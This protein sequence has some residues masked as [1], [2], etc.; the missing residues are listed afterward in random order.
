MT[1]YGGKAGD[2][3]SLMVASQ[4]Y[5]ESCHSVGIR[6]N[7]LFPLAYKHTRISKF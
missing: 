2:G 3:R 5:D 4:N 1:Y 6:E 7:Q